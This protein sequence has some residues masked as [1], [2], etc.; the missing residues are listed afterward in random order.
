MFCIPVPDSKRKDA[1]FRFQRKQMD[2]PD[3]VKSSDAVPSP[4]IVV[5]C[6]CIVLFYRHKTDD[7][8]HLRKEYQTHLIQ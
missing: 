5:D 2:I 4:S 3:I 7:K 8:N 6:L 1:T